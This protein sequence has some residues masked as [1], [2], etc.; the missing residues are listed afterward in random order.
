MR[1]RRIYAALAV[2]TTAAALVGCSSPGYTR[3]ALLNRP[4]G[5]NGQLEQVP[6][7][8]G[9]SV[10]MTMFRS[11]G[12]AGQHDNTRVVSAPID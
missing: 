4:G 6:M 8:A 5:A 1:V 11:G 2:S 10:A 3:Q 9:D 12:F 7:V